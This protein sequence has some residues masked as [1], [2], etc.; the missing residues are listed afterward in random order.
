MKAQL[1]QESVVHFAVGRKH[2]HGVEAIRVAA[3]VGHHVHLFAVRLCQYLF[4]WDFVGRIRRLGAG[5]E[6]ADRADRREVDDWRRIGLRPFGHD[7][8][9]DLRISNY[10]LDR[11]SYAVVLCAGY[12]HESGS[13]R[14]G[15]GALYAGAPPRGRRGD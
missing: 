1:L 10:E 15:I 2:L 13:S 8:W 9:N 6:G 14:R 5:Q 12:R 3:E 7:Y 11:I 4:D